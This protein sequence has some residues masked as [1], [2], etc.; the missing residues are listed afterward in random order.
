MLNNLKFVSLKNKLT[1]FLVLSTISACITSQNI[2]YAD[3]FYGYPDTTKSTGPIYLDTSQTNKFTPNN[4]SIPYNL[5]SF[6]EADYFSSSIDDVPKATQNSPPIMSLNDLPPPSEYKLTKN[7][8]KEPEKSANEE[9]FA[10]SSVATNFFAPVPEE[11]EIKETEAI[12]TTPI[13][14]ENSEKVEIQETTEPFKEIE[15]P[16][17]Y[18]ASASQEEVDN[19]SLEGCT[20]SKVKILGLKSLSPELILSK[21]DSQEGSL[22]NNDILQRDL[23]KI[24]ATGYFTDEMS[25]EPE[26]KDDGTVELTYTLKEN[27]IVSDVSIIGNTVISTM[28]LSP[29]VISMKGKPQNL[30]AINNAIEGITNTYHDKGYILANI[31]SVDDDADGNLN[32]NIQEGVIDKIKISGNEK[33]QEYVIM[34]NIMTQPNTVY[35]EEFLKKDLSKVFSTQ[36]FDE[37]NRDIRPSEENIGTYDITIVVKEKSTD[38]IALGGG[39]DTGLG[40]FGSISLR[41]DNFLGRAQK[42][43]LTGILGSGI[44]LSDASIKN[45]MNYQAELSFFEPHF[46]N[47]DNSLTSK[48]Y[49]REMGSFNIPLA[50]ERRIGLVGAVEHKVKD[51]EHLTTSFMLGAEHIHLKEGDANTISQLYARNG[52]N[53]TDR[54]KQLQGGFFLNLAPGIK[55]SNLDD[56]ENP[57][58]GII[59]QARYN[60]AIGISNINHTNGRLSGMVTKFFPVFKK[61][62]FSL[63]AKGG[64]KIHGD[65]MPE[66]MAYRLGGPYT[67][68]GY[69]MH[70]VG[71]GESFFMGS[72]ELA[73]PLPFVDRLKW[74]FIKKMRLTF[75]V[76]AGKVFNP[77]MSNILFDRPEHAITAGIGLRIFIPGL[78]PISVDYG[79]PITNPGTFG[80]EHG[81]FTFGTGGLNGLYGY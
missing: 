11:E 76:D 68:R 30:Y 66:I 18:F 12:F 13:V 77:T 37:V 32:F 54:A 29:F 73:T 36:I 42:V 75:F 8:V 79:L 57:R 28:E 72:A 43:S 1:A 20:I 60:E 78:G 5:R 24:Y 19:S 47:A 14:S 55:Y 45:H 3:G 41:E 65:N 74:D 7:T 6:N 64:I 81:Y 16:A 40:A 53:I 48:L 9:T 35:N 51:Y 33:T 23:Q 50:I 31:K 10:P 4:T 61:S 26:L 2:S 63:T 27:I 62:T 49:F 39:I 25:V 22:F 80:S 44:L 38:S 17:S 21:I 67:I 15:E 58:E 69:R 46:I 70:G 59:A 34:R 56:Y 52:L 71:A